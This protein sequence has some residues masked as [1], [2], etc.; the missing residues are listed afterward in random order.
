MTDSG[1]L[2]GC[3]YSRGNDVKAEIIDIGRA[4]SDPIGVIGVAD[5]LELAPMLF[6]DDD[7]T[8]TDAVYT[9]DPLAFKPAANALIIDQ[10]DDGKNG[11]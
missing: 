10:I 4:E 11:T 5:D 3:L 8:G 9:L 6:I 1:G 7:G 2:F